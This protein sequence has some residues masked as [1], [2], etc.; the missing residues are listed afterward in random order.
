[1]RIENLTHS[2]QQGLQDAQSLAV[3]SDH[4]QIEAAHLLFTMLNQASSSVAA[5]YGLAEVDV[6]QL[7]NHC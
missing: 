3:Q 7:K 6:G 2:F 5:I 1:M 4:P